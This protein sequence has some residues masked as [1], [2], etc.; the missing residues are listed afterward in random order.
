MLSLKVC[1]FQVYEGDDNANNEIH[2]TMRAFILN[3]TDIQ[4]IGIC[5]SPWSLGSEQLQIFPRK[6]MLEYPTVEQ[7]KMFL[8]KR[9]QKMS[10][11]LS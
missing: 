4:I 2:E 6:K 7:T 1:H 10:H 3:S 11:S 5:S 8:E 9:F